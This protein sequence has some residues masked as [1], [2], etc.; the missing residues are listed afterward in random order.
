MDQKLELILKKLSSLESGQKELNQKFEAL[1]SGQKELNNKFEVLESGQKELG[2]IVRTIR[3]RQEETD[4][5]IDAL[6][7]DV[8]HVHGEI[9]GV[10]EEIKDLR[11]GVIFV[12][13][14]VADAEF[15]INMMK[16]NKNQ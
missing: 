5:K 6:S 1:E 4:A 10:K 15:E 11:N 12:N 7:M 3:D 16:Q 9:A 2:Q 8:H 14:K 13:R